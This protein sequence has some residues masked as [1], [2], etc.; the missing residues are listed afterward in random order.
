[1][2]RRRLRLVFSVW[3]G[4]A[5]QSSPLRE[6]LIRLFYFGSVGTALGYT[7]QATAASWLM[8]TLTPS[9][10][11]V[12]LVQTA[13]TLPTLL[14]GLVAGSLA[15]IVDRKKVIM[16]TQ[17]AMLGTVTLLAAAVLAGVIGP[18][19]L[20]VLPFP[21]GCGFTSYLPAQQ[22]SVLRFGQCVAGRRA[23]C[24]RASVPEPSLVPGRSPG[25][26]SGPVCTTL[27][28]TGF[29]GGQLA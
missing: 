3:L 4:S 5:L 20:L 13:S 2:S 26:S 29:R 19:A 12:A 24:R 6:P 21:I 10:L 25:S 28:R 9:A 14:F 15:D 17:L 8:A 1:L 16:L 27:N 7:M 11:M 22:T 18:V 23:Y